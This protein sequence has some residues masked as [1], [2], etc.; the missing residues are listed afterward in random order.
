M[1]NDDFDCYMTD[2][3]EN[4][5][6]RLKFVC[7]LNLPFDPATPLRTWSGTDSSVMSL[8]SFGI[9]WSIAIFSFVGTC[10]FFWIQST[11]CLAS[12]FQL[13]WCFILSPCRPW[14]VWWPWWS[15]FSWWNK[16][17]REFCV[18]LGFPVGPVIM[19]VS[20]ALQSHLST[21]FIALKR[22]WQVSL[23]S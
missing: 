23:Y 1:Y 9:W 19:V 13:V 12:V 5:L 20:R 8:S 22:P 11:L 16:I 15:L 2:P 4:Q 21:C 14:F 17:Y 6:V 3:Y 10:R 7:L 18:F